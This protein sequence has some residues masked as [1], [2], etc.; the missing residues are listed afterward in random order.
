MS[1]RKLLSIYEKLTSIVFFKW[2]FYVEVSS[3]E[4]YVN[5]VE[6]TRLNRVV[7]Q[8]KINLILYVAIKVMEK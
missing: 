5:L 7:V 1:E 2:L 6:S 8:P 4:S 3:C